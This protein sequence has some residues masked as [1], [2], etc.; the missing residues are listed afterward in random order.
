M[1]TGVLVPPQGG[2]DIICHGLATDR[3]RKHFVLAIR[4][5]VLA[6]AA[7][8]ATAR[9]RRA[10]PVGL[11]LGNRRSAQRRRWILLGSLV[12][13]GIGFPAVEAHAKV[14]AHVTARSVSANSVSPFEVTARARTGPIAP[15]VIEADTASAVGVAITGPTASPAPVDAA[16][17]PDTSTYVGSW[18]ASTWRLEIAE[19]SPDVLGIVN[20]APTEYEHC[21]EPPGTKIFSGFVASTSGQWNGAVRAISS[22]CSG[23][24][25]WWQNAAMRAVRRHDGKIALVLAWGRGASTAPRPSIDA[26]GRVTSTGPYTGTVATRRLSMV[27]LGDSVSAGEGIGNR[28]KWHPGDKFRDETATEP[29]YYKGDWE[30]DGVDTTWRS[31]YVSSECHQTSYSHPRVAAQDLGADVLP[32]SCTGSTSYDGVLSDRHKDGPA[33]T[34]ERQLGSSVIA[35]AAA[36]NAKYDAAKPDI[37]TLSLGANDVHFAEVLGDCV[38]GGC[39]RDLTDDLAKAKR[40]VRLVL[41]EIERRGQT[42]G[43][44][45]LVLLTHYVDPFP[46]FWSKHCTDLDIPTPG[47]SV[48]RDE[49]QYL[50]SW[51]VKL[52]GDLTDLADEFDNVVEVRQPSEHNRHDFCTYDPWTFGLSIAVNERHNPESPFHPTI[53][54]QRSLAA[55][56]GGAARDELPVRAGTG[57][58]VR[59]ASG[60]QLRFAE[61][62]TDGSVILQRADAT[63]LQ[64]ASS[65]AATGMWTIDSSALYT[66]PIEITLPGSDGQS[67]YHFTGGSWRQLTTSHAGGKLTAT[68]MSLSPFAVGAPAS[69]VT[70]RIEPI[71]GGTAPAAV[72]LDAST[73]TVENGSAIDSYFWDFGDGETATGAT[74]A[75]TFAQSGTF[76]VSVRVR[77]VEGSVDVT[78]AQ[79]TV[80]NPAPRAAISGPTTGRVGELL[81]FGSAGSSD[82]NGEIVDRGFEFDDGSPPQV[83]ATAQRSFSQPGEHTVKLRV[84]DDEGEEDVASLTVRIAPPT[85]TPPPPPPPPLPP[86]PLPPPLLPA[87]PRPPPP[88][89]PPPLSDTK[90][91][92]LKLAGSRSQKVRKTVSVK[93][94]CPDE[95]CG[96]KAQG[97]VRVPKVGRIKATT[98]RLKQVVKEIAKDKRVTLRLKLSAKARR[99]IKRAL[100]RHK[101]VTIELTIRVS[102]AAGNTR[103]RAR[104]IKMKQ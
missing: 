47:L 59:Y 15:D 62:T 17:P 18:T 35:G 71:V 92:G 43:K 49:M 42:A 77:S 76:T 80:T 94:S 28:W 72:T 3:Q 40:D 9:S 13:V 33:V 70:A 87:S 85:G 79:V 45:P 12:V 95:A 30:A 67:I 5:L 54:G 29:A 64:P 84:A 50:R 65:F 23:E 86:P 96:V 53:D 39:T 81:T 88:P 57:T 68:T 89:P 55:A 75:H 98:Y 99:A 100:R 48:E 91:P 44:V 31:D 51:L 36:P 46:A 34:E 60:E 93:V 7:A 4:R 66:G 26:D 97:I 61:V 11:V 74:P 104:T 73:S 102:D 41:E 82:P 56:I 8:S 24:F 25:Q 58:T 10:I 90:A 19:E 2:H 6:P 16:P 20:Q 32:L 63:R 27:A 78:E 52:N 37:V 38:F 22:S 103:T 14:D 101:T 83:S 69:P 1:S 21:T